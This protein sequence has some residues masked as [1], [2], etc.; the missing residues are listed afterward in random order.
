MTKLINF[1]NE[2]K[3]EIANEPLEQDFAL[4]SRLVELPFEKILLNDS[5]DNPLLVDACRMLNIYL[6][7]KSYI[8]LP[9]D[10]QL[11]NQIIDSNRYAKVSIANIVSDQ[12]QFTAMTF[13]L[14]KSSKI[15]AFRGSNGTLLSWQDD[16]H[17]SSNSVDFLAQQAQNYLRNEIQ[18]D[19]RDI[20][21][22]G[23][24]RGAA[25]AALAS[26]DIKPIERR[27]IRTILFDSPGLPN[28]QY[29]FKIP[30]IELVTPLSIFALIGEHPF[31]QLSIK[32]STQGIW[33]HNLY[34]WVGDLNGNFE[35]TIGISANK[36]TY[37][38]FQMLLPQKIT[39][40]NIKKSIN[41]IFSIF[42]KL[43]YQTSSDLIK[44]WNQFST[45]I[46]VE[47]KN[48]NIVVKMLINRLQNLI[49]KNAAINLQSIPLN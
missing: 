3:K 40:E 16:L 32:N 22:T 23:F 13:L 8:I 34:S 10:Q 11:L 42:S 29:D 6:R 48:E 43:E 12:E 21:C 5:L 9:A 36:V 17:F 2:Y 1:L 44:H 33:Q 15:I 37:H 19:Q 45:L 27:V 26:T 7:Q 30:I 4:F 24:S 31:P 25:V 20:F 47:T 38:Q 46:K 14:S 49:F 35:R 18:A 39:D 41:V 28:G